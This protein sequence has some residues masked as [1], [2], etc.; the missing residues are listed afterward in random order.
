MATDPLVNVWQPTHANASSYAIKT[1]DIYTSTAASV[2]YYTYKT[3]DQVLYEEGRHN[4][5]CDYIAG[6]INQLQGV[7]VR[8][9]SAFLMS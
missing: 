1:S 5:V 4:D 9:T 6:E 8:L 3:V 7:Y 2:A